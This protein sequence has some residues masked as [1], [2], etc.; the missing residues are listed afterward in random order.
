ML[1][2]SLQKFLKALGYASMSNQ[3][4]QT[5][6]RIQMHADKL[7]HRM[8][9]YETSVKEAEEKG[10]KPPPYKPLFTPEVEEASSFPIDEKNRHQHIP[11]SMLHKIK[12]PLQ[13]MTPL[14]QEVEVR[15]LKGEM[16]VLGSHFDDL[17][18]TLLEEKFKKLKRKEKM[19]G[20][21]GDWAANWIVP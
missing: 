12:K 13:K 6:E 21:V 15:A 4:T 5:A 9:D 19:A 11:P 14:E 1:I 8:L 10:L 18:D 16:R 17:E 20:W 3:D 2:Q 7:Y